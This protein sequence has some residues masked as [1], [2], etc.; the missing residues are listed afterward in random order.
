MTTTNINN[1]GLCDFAVVN[2]DSSNLPFLLND[3]TGEFINVP[4]SP[5][6]VPE[7]RPRHILLGDITGDAVLDAVVANILPNTATVLTGLGDGSF[8]SASS[9]LS[10]GAGAQSVEFVKF[11][12]RRIF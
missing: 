3:G 9:G 7:W 5:F 12:W 4:G 2:T 10:I 6:E 8:Q 1:D 11:E